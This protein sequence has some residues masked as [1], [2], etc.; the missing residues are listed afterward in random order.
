MSVAQAGDRTSPPPLDAF[1]VGTNVEAIK[2][3]LERR[4]IDITEYCLIF[5]VKQILINNLF[6]L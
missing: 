3:I 1:D 2:P 6:A 4:C 5:Y